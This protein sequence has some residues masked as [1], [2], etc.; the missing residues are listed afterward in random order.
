M[1]T[2]TGG[3]R[4]EGAMTPTS[5]RERLVAN[6]RWLRSWL[7]SLKVDDPDL[8]LWPG[9]SPEVVRA[10][11]QV[12][13]QRPVYQ[14]DVPLVEAWFVL[15][16]EK[17]RQVVRAER[18]PESQQEDVVQEALTRVMESL[19]RL[20]PAQRPSTERDLR[21][22]ALGFLRNVILEQRRD[23]GRLV[24]SDAVAETLETRADAG[25]G[26]AIAWLSAGFFDALEKLPDA[27][28]AAWLAIDLEDADIHLYAEVTG[29]PYHTVCSSLKAARTKLEPA[30]RPHR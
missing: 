12:V 3:P 11:E 27:Q 18:V 4:M 23:A 10:V 14:R 21:R 6:Q 26:A 17:M 8:A 25:A 28:R 1:V 30:L 16:R 20:D 29:K 5:W 2:Q 7:R 9:S 19:P 15:A 22:W 24:P 13:Q